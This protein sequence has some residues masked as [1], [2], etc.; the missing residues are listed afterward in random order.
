MS[1]NSVEINKIV[2]ELQKLLPPSHIEKII[3]ID[4]SVILFKLYSNGQE[5][6]LLLSLKSQEIRLHLSQQR[7][8][9]IDKP[10]TFL[11]YL[12]KHI[13]NG[14][15]EEISTLNE[16]RIV[17]CKIKKG[18]HTFYLIFDMIQKLQNAY[19]LDSN[20]KILFHLSPLMR[21]M[22][23]GDL[24]IPPE[25]KAYTVKKIIP[26]EADKLYNQTIEEYY[27]EKL[28]NKTYLD[29]LNKIASTLKS[30]L[31]NSSKLVNNLKKQHDDCHKWQEWQQKGELLKS[32][33]QLLKKGEKEIVLQNYFEQNLPEITITLDPQKSPSE[34]VEVCFKKSKKLQSGLKH[35]SEKLIKAETSLVHIKQVYEAFEKVSD[36]AGLDEFI[37]QFQ[38]EKLLKKA[39]I[40]KKARQKK[41]HSPSLPY[42]EF[43]STSNKKIYVGKSSKD[44]DKLTFSIGKGN[45]IWLH[46]RD[47]GGSHVIV[48]L[49]K[50]EEIDQESLLDAANLALIY[51]K[52]KKHQ[53]GEIIYTK[54]KFISKRKKSP[55]GEVQVSEFKTI[56]IKLDSQRLQA[57]KER[58]KNEAF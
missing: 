2:I 41:Q 31:K 25:K 36:K 5:N 42:K 7:R 28:T 11:L 46:V 20:K 37:N 33:F 3:E 54:R 1:L 58:S 52:A 56:Y 13:Q 49:N 12:R 21:D 55:A 22:K 38:N 44:N 16:D 29:Q 6:V 8:K 14:Y 10:S 32:H 50:S 23:S 30:E 15:L 34:N 47:Y 45:D 40:D 4:Q 27:T 17:Q 57:I 26:E 43:I 19:V 48:P 9:A 35:I 51:S 39:F 18:D 24:Y 53:E